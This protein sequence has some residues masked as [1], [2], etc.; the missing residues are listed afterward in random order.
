VS[1]STALATISFLSN[2]YLGSNE[3]V[4]E[5]NFADQLSKEGKTLIPF[6]LESFVSQRQDFVVSSSFTSNLSLLRVIFGPI[7]TDCMRF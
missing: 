5:L 2:A 4:K 3:C 7:L 6:F 1:Q